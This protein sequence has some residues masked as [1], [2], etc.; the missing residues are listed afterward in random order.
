MPEEKNSDDKNKLDPP[1][2][3]IPSQIPDQKPE[4]TKPD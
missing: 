2:D 4:W 3:K 1:L